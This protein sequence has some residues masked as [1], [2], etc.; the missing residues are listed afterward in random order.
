M[1]GKIT[2]LHIA[3]RC[4]SSA[5]AVAGRSNGSATLDAVGPPPLT[6]PRSARCGP[7]SCRLLALAFSAPRPATARRLPGAL[8]PRAAPV[9]ARARAAAHPEL[10]RISMVTLCNSVPRERFA[11]GGGCLRNRHERGAQNERA[12]RVVE[13]SS[14]GTAPALAPPTDSASP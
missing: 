11:P 5:V 9:N 2:C 6:R 8:A 14:Y 3:P 13:M 1:H 4:A 7:Q 10:S 12:A